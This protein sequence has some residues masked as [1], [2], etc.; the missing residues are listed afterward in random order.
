MRNIKPDG[1][2]NNRWRT[3]EF[4]R[5]RNNLFWRIF[6]HCSNVS[7]SDWNH[8]EKCMFKSEKLLLIIQRLIFGSL[9]IHQC[10]SVDFCRTRAK[11]DILQASHS[12]LFD[13]CQSF[14]EHLYSPRKRDVFLNRLEWIVHV[15]VYIWIPMEIK[16]EYIWIDRHVI[17]ENVGDVFKRIRKMRHSPRLN[18]DRP[19]R[20]RSQGVFGQKTMKKRLFYGRKWTVLFL[21]RGHSNTVL[22]TAPYTDKI[23]S[24][25]LCQIWRR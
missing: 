18:P 3:K 19:K 10:L 16:R 25:F 7:A 8:T 24:V 15:F 12:I 6:F 13:W 1:R 5:D 11:R 4:L 14:C 9:F 21:N 23:W 2:R 17:E 22:Y 20:H